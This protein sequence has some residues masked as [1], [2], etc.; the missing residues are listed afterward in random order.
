MLSNL[1]KII[2]IKKCIVI[3]VLCV[4]TLSSF[5][6]KIKYKDVKTDYST[7]NYFQIIEKPKRSLL[8]ASGLTL[9]YPGIGHVYIGEPLRGVC[10][11]GAEV[12]SFAAFFCGMFLAVE[13]GSPVLAMS[14]LIAMPVVYLWSLVD[15]IRVAQIKNLAYQ[16]RNISMGIYP[17][18][19]FGGVVN[20]SNTVA[21]GLSLSVRF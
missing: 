12:I 17:S 4:L 7:K 13:Y 10:F 6:Q 15:V 9:L 5:S 2:I 20:N 14:G 21:C 18:L 16:N 11:F 8:L 19:N 3:I 1:L